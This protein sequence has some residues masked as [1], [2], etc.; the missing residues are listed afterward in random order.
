M[1]GYLSSKHYSFVDQWV[2]VLSF[3]RVRMIMIGIDST[4]VYRE[5]EKMDGI[6]LNSNQER[7]TFL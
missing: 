2:S 1:L 5:G 3:Y 4:T 7:L 6:S